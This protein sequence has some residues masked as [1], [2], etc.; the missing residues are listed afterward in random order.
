ML[1]DKG[2]TK[3]KTYCPLSICNEKRARAR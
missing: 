1:M 3:N 2:I